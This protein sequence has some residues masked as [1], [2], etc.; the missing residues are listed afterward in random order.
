MQTVE[1]DSNQ[2]FR[3][4][5][6][7][8]FA[9]LLAKAGISGKGFGRTAQVAANFSVSTA[10]AQK[11][12][13]GKSLPEPHRWPE[14]C[15]FLN[16]SLD[17]LFFGDQPPFPKHKPDGYLEMKVIAGVE[18]QT[19]ITRQILVEGLDNNFSFPNHFWF[20]VN[21]NTMEPFVMSGDWVLV[22]PDHQIPEGSSVMLLCVEEHF[23]IRRVQL[24]MGGEVV[25]IPEN[26][27]YEAEIVTSIAALG[28]DGPVSS[29]GPTPRFVGE[30]VG[31]LLVNR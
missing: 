11:W 21:D 2:L 24:R 19:L 28:W 1:H 4:A 17:E 8:R 18:G 10:T 12:L 30:V 3:D 26:K 7:R 6:A 16:C 27:K 20:H 25:L 23:F 22:N 5:F 31:R 14:I 13:S 29:T 15:T 9:L